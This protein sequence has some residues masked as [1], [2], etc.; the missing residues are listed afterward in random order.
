MNWDDA[1]LTQESTAL[2]VQLLHAHAARSDRLYGTSVLN[3]QISLAI[4]SKSYSPR[5]L[6]SFMTRNSRK[7]SLKQSFISTIGLSH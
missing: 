7:S 6:G 1:G 2:Y 5:F 3:N 4:A